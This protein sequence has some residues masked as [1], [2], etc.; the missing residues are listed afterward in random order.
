MSTKT[1]TQ[2]TTAD[3]VIAAQQPSAEGV[4]I[5]KRKMFLAALGLAVGGGAKAQQKTRAELL[6]E[7]RKGRAGAASAAAA[8]P[9]P[10]QRPARVIP[11]TPTGNATTAGESAAAAHSREVMRGSD[12]YNPDG[13]LKPPSRQEVAPPPAVVVAA[14]RDP[15]RYSNSEGIAEVSTNA[16]FSNPQAK[17]VFEN[18]KARYAPDLKTG[19]YANNQRPGSVP[20][21]E[22]LEQKMLSNLPPE[23]AKKV[24]ANLVL[25]IRQNTPGGGMNAQGF[26]AA[27]ATHHP[28]IANIE[29]QW[30]LGSTTKTGDLGQFLRS[31]VKRENVPATTEP[32]NAVVQALPPSNYEEFLRMAPKMNNRIAAAR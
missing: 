9:S 25:H 21:L 15:V 31:P 16:T 20:G 18:M 26:L 24:L 27:L 1:T 32:M 6:E 11:G 2:L 28:R 29:Y 23:D 3:E 30:K 8:A 22:Q 14:E 19:F 17:E 13:T 4:D 5:S 7:L 12:A 10:A